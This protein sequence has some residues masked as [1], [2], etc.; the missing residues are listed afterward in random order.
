VTAFA[1]DDDARLTYRVYMLRAATFMGAA[2]VGFPTAKQEFGAKTV[3]FRRA[4]RI[5]PTYFRK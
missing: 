1:Y 5:F 2:P 3:R 4:M